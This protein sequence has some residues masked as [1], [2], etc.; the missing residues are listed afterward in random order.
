VSLIE[1]REP[2]LHNFSFLTP[3]PNTALYTA[4]QRWIGDRDYEQW[5][6]FNSTCIPVI[7]KLIPEKQGI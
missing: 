1:R 7:S 2:S 5:N 4:T 6:D 3:F